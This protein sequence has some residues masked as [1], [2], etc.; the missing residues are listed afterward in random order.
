MKKK[1]LLL[2]SLAFSFYFSK[3]QKQDST[4][5]VDQ[6]E[7]EFLYNHYLQDGDNSAVTGGRGTESLTVFGPSLNVVRRKNKNTYSFQA[8]VDVIS[9]ASTDN[10]DFVQSSAS[11]RDNRVYTNIGY[12]RNVKNSELI[13]NTGAGFS[14]ESDYLS[15]SYLLGMSKASKNGMQSFSAQIQYYNDDLRWGR[16]DKDFKRPVGLVYPVEL[17]YKEWH[18]EY[19]RH[20]FNLNMGFTQVIGKRHV[21]GVFSIVAYQKGLLATPF[22]R[23]IFNDDSKAVEMLPDERLKGALAFKWNYF[24]GGRVVIKNTINGYHDS[25]D[26][27]GLS[28]ENETAIKLNPRWVV[29]PGFRI[30]NQK[31][32]DF[33]AEYGQHQPSSRY[34]TSDFDLSSFRSFKINF[35]AKYAP[36]LKSKVPLESISLRYGYYQRSNH[37]DGHILSLLLRLNYD[38]NLR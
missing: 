17:R 9:S 32:A 14:M 12:A 11:S 16:L 29:L 15:F 8:G 33:F 28:F 13:L 10:I 34:Q 22:H 19:R 37:L 18:V 26:I 38:H 4:V 20:S 3:A 7:I 36:Y 25:F 31:G 35:G 5:Q 30:F 27:S 2:G 23:I 24:V 21:L 6:T 1:Y